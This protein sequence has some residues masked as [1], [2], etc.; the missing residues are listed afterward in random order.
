MTR[1]KIQT[2]K[3]TLSSK[4]TLCSHF[5]FL[6]N[7]TIQARNSGAGLRIAHICLL[8]DQALSIFCF[9]T[10]VPHVSL[11]IYICIYILVAQLVEHPALA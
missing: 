10:F 9:L 6:K 4:P 8:S 5:P 7:D 1:L 11:S 3:L 2:V